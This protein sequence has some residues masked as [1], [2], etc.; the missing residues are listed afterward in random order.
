MP[1]RK[2]NVL[3]IVSFKVFPALMGGQKY[4][5][6]YY[7]ALSK[8]TNV[9]LAVSKDNKEAVLTEKELNVLPFLFNHWYGFLNLIYCFKLVQIIKREKID[10]IIIDHSYF[11]WLGILLRWLTG[12]KLVIKSANLEA[13]RFRD[14]GRWGWQAYELYEKCVHQKADRNFFIS[15]EERLYAIEHWSVNPTISYT[16]PY[17]ITTEEPCA[18]LEK[19]E[20]R[21]T[22]LA[23][24]SLQANTKLFLFNGTLDYI[25]NEDAL[26]IILNELVPRLNQSKI[27]YRIFVCGVQIKPNWEVQLLACSTIIYTGFV[28]NI[29]LYNQGTDCFI[30]PITLGAGVKTKITDAIAAC[31]MVIACKK[32]CEGLN[33][34]MLSQQ[35]IVIDDYN[36]DGFAKAMI[37]ISVNEIPKTPIAFYTAY[38]WANIVRESILYLPK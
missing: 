3:G 6:D 19:T 33:Q 31:Q 14:M 9:V 2:P 8:Q 5:V 30:S 12:K 32:S 36:W 18:P 21:N 4:I 34:S 20:S 28:E 10:I 35:L 24:H 37:Q 27:S 26:Y 7:R 17:G 15:D 25:P 1:H 22:I 13:F 16:V 23:L 11:G 38:N 29:Q